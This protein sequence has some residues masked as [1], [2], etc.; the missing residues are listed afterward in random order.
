MRIGVLAGWP[1]YGIDG[2]DLYLLDAFRGVATAAA[3]RTCNVLF[4]A[5]LATAARPQ[6]HS[7]LPYVGAHCHYVPV[8]AFNTDGLILIPPFFTGL[9]AEQMDALAHSGTPC[10]FLGQPGPGPSVISDTEA[11]LATAIAHLK[12]LGH[13]DIAFVAGHKVAPVNYST[14]RL[15]FDEA[16]R[17]N[18][19]RVD[20]ARVAYGLHSRPGGCAAM[21]TL[22]AQAHQTSSPFSAVVVDGDESLVG[23]M[24]ALRDAG[25]RVPHDIAVIAYNNSLQSQTLAPPVTV[26]HQQTAEIGRRAAHLLLDLLTLTRTGDVARADAVVSVPEQ[27]IVRESCGARLARQRRRV[28]LAPRKQPDADE[29]L[30]AEMVDAIRLEGGDIGDEALRDICRSVVSAWRAYLKR[31]GGEAHVVRW[32]QALTAALERSRSGLEDARAWHTALSSLPALASGSV[33]THVR[34][35]RVSEAIHQAHVT[36]AQFV[37][38]QQAQRTQARLRTTERMAVL[39]A[40]L[41]TATSDAEIM[42]VAAAGLLELD[43]QLLCIA[44]LD[45]VTQDDGVLLSDAAQSR[46]RYAAWTLGATGVTTTWREAH[47]FPPSHRVGAGKSEALLVIPFDVDGAQAGFVAITLEGIALGGAITQQIAGAIRSSRLYAQLAQARAW[48]G[49]CVWPARLLRALAQRALAYIHAHYAGDTTR[50]RIAAHV[51]IHSDYLTYIFRCETGLTPIA[52]LNR[53]R[54]EQ[55]CRMIGSGKNITEV[56]LAV[57]FSDL[58]YFSRVFRRQVGV[59][60]LRFQRGRTMRRV[61]ADD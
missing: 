4:A 26:I 40:R 54:I 36:V 44:L 28:S 38:Q 61:T 10:V 16:M 31:D 42:Q 6:P 45:G 9:T 22:L 60:P 33:R 3:E 14:H 35:A 18:H 1:L 15:A 43:T 20:A 56:A 5:G 29:A 11:G 50:E 58:S 57:G 12:S 46:L 27:L 41:L 53:F 24:D 49:E 25:L 37:Q 8:G 2:P 7:A 13:T 48:R 21:Q 47:N 19:L 39:S 30:L 32:L 55:A 59:S 23:V 52:Y 51:G 34:R 17:Q